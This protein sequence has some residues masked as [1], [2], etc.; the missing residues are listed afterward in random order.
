LQLAARVGEL[1]MARVRRIQAGN[2]ARPGSARVVGS[3][4]RS[5]AA[6]TRSLDLEALNTPEPP[7]GEVADRLL[8]LPGCGPYATA[9]MMM[10]LGRYYSRLILDSWTGPK[11]DRLNGRE[12]SDKT[13]ER[14]YRRYGDNA[15]A[16]AGRTG[17]LPLPPLTPQVPPWPL[18][19]GR[20]CE[21]SGS[22]RFDSRHPA[23][24][25]CSRGGTSRSAR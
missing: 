13:S 5:K 19:P 6:A 9:H 2:R 24:D 8:A 20:A 10:L 17:A 7:D 18:L 1:K 14:R 3:K 25:R 16:P 4:T 23:F 15:G 21:P 12:A 11:Y 22:P